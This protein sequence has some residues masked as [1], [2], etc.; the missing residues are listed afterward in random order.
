MVQ[1]GSLAQRPRSTLSQSQRDSQASSLGSQ[2]SGGTP[3]T[4]LSYDKPPPGAFTNGNMAS[5]V[6]VNTV[7]TNQTGEGICFY[8]H[9][10]EPSFPPHKFRNQCPWYKFHL[11]QGTIHLNRVNKLCL[12]PERDGAPEIFLTRDAPHNAQVHM[13]TAGTEFDKNIKDCPKEQTV[14]GPSTAVQGLT[15]ISEESDSSEEDE[16]EGFGV[17]K[18]REITEANASR[19]EFPPPIAKEKWVNPTKILKRR[20][21]KE[22]EKTYAVGKRLRLGSWEL[23]QVAETDEEREQ[24]DIEIPDAPPEEL[25]KEKTPE[26]AKPTR[27]AVPRKKYMDVLKEE[28]N[29]EELLKKIMDQRVNI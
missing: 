10:R 9:N 29:P 2:R 24:F 1:S 27:K 7:S 11:T 16:L 18:E 17:V 5:T 15:F 22:K 23:A 3:A 26:R 13:R 12:G 19:I 21:E 4:G 6:T 20:V 28:Q 25:K 8:C 14:S